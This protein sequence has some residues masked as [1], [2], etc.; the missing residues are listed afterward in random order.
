MALRDDNLE[1]LRRKVAELSVVIDFV[2]E[3]YE[4]TIELMKDEEDLNGVFDGIRQALRKSFDIVH[5]ARLD[6][7]DLFWESGNWKHD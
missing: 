1:A 7:E 3:E 4:N 2:E 6:V 5:F